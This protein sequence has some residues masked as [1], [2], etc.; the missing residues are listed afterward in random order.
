[1]PARLTREEIEQALAVRQF[2]LVRAAF[3]EME[4]ADVADA[5]EAL[6]PE[7][8]AV[9]FRVLRRQQA[10]EVFE[11]LEA[12]IQESLI[13]ALARE[14]VAAILNDMSPDDRTALLEELP[15]EVTKPLLTLLTP[16]ERQVARQLLGYPEDSI[17]RLMT[18][19]FIAVRADWTVRQ[20]LDHIRQHGDDSET[21]SVINVVDGSGRLIDDLRVRQLLL[22]ELD[23]RIADIGD[24]S[25]ISLGAMDDQER[26]VEVFREY[27]R[28]A[29]PVTDSSGVLLGIVTVD[30]VL[31]VAEE[32]AT[33]DIQKIGGSG[34]LEQPYMQVG[35]FSMLRKRAGW[36]VVL[37]LGQQL[38]LIAMGHF[39][40][41]LARALVL[42]MF[43]PLVISSGGNSGSQAATM[44]IRA[45][46]LGELRLGDWWKVIRREFLLGAS[47]GAVL[48]IIGFLRIAVGEGLAGSYGAEW[49]RVALAVGLS[50]VFVVLWGVLVG[51]MLPFVLS[52]LGA[53]PAAS[54]TPFVATLVDVTGLSIY[55][56]I[57]TL[58]LL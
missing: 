5:I 32:E 53:D 20:A 58:I 51:S 22:A 48:A 28:V 6:G 15:A 36:L 46:A 43:V 14:H 19:D 24:G 13:R 52:W 26:A 23:A 56:T 31:D 34:A 29:F 38:T 47:L 33:E 7:D 39:A 8:R 17:G 54:S 25:F 42:V 44:V 10:A 21:L 35:F 30:D 37:F 57:G 49:A 45:M 41:Q 1:M 12:E 27:D 55:L 2:S 3:G 4:T 50:L 11:Y 9:A 40:D 18:P 16:E